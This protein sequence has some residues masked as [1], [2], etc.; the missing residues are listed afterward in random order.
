[1]KLYAK[2]FMCAAIVISAALLLS[3]YLLITSSHEGALAREK[4]RAANQFRYG[5]F[6]V[7]A[8]IFSPEPFRF[9]ALL[10]ESG[11]VVFSNFPQEKGFSL[12]ETVSGNNYAMRFENIGGAVHIVVCGRAAGKYLFTASDISGVIAHRQQ[13]LQ[14]FAGIYFFTLVLGMVLML[15]FSVIIVRPVKKMN[16]VAAKIAQGNYRER[17][18]FYGRDEIGELAHSFNLMAEAIEGKINELQDTARRKE[19]FV[20]NFAHEL[21]TPLTSVIGYADMIYQKNLPPQQVKDAASYI[22]NEG[23]RLESLALKLMD[24]TVLKRQEF[25][26]EELN[27]Q[28]LFENISQSLKP[29][30]NKHGATLN[31]H[32][33]PATIRVEYDLFK[34]LIFNLIDN[35]VKADGKKI[36]IIG[37]RHGEKYAITVADNGRGIPAREL[38]K[39]TEA[40]YTVDKSRSNGAGIGL[41]LA[42][43]IAEIHGSKLLFESTVKVGTVVTISLE[44][45]F[46]E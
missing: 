37:T 34:T 46:D 33:Q 19:E 31:L 10:D 42:E 14:N 29:M 27:A 28:E 38:T 15:I 11:Q 39:I 21:K 9:A 6:T 40:F 30:L 22:L 8:D 23:L 1:M 26:M 45:D 43:K 32:I 41:T 2:F 4:E 44:A 36:D 16:T 17:L 24:L 25:I 20:A 13:M 18:Q 35:A 3:G 12:M 7:Q 5:R